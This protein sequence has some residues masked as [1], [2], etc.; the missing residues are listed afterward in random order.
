MET[1]EESI[2]HG[3]PHAAAGT[4]VDLTLSAQVPL[5]AYSPEKHAI[6]VTPTE[7]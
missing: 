3:I 2:A 5:P 4:A 7:H 6:V 1:C